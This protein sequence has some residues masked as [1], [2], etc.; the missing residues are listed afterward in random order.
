MENELSHHI[1]YKKKDGCS[2][3]AE[4]ALFDFVPDTIFGLSIRRACCIHDDR[5]ERGGVEQDRT[6]ADREFLE[7]ML[8]IIG[9]YKKWYYPHWFA[10]HRAMTY[11]DAVRRYG[12]KSF[13]Y[14]GI[15]K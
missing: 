4:D 1:H 5:Y 14:K 11:F 6:F 7:N 10:R 3:G 15:R 2:C 13:N 8:T 9:N 12:G